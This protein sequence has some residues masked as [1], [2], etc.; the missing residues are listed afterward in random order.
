MTSVVDDR[1]LV[2]WNSM[3]FAWGDNTLAQRVTIFAVDNHDPNAP[4]PAPS[5]SL[6]SNFRT[7]IT[8][9]FRGNAVLDD[10][11]PV[12]KDEDMLRTFSRALVA[13][14]FR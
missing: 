14:Q 12:F 4:F 13:A 7:L 11:T 3:Q 6:A 5:V 2:T 8:L 9:L 1:L 10:R